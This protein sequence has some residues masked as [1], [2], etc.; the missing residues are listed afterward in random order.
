MTVVVDA[1]ANAQT[2]TS[3]VAHYVS[4]YGVVSAGVGTGYVFSNQN[5]G[6]VLTVA[7]S[8]VGN[9]G[10]LTDGGGDQVI[11]TSTGSISAAEGASS[12]AIILGGAGD[13][14]RISGNVSAID[15][16]VGVVA[17]DTEVVVSQSG[18]VQGGASSPTT[19]R[20][21]AAVLAVANTRLV[22]NGDIIADVNA[23][24]SR[25]AVANASHITPRVDASG[26]WLD[27][28]FSLHFTNTGFV[29]GAVL[30]GAGADTYDGRG[31]GVVEGVIDMGVDDDTFF[32]GDFEEVVLGGRGYDTL[33]GA[34]GPDTLTG[35]D[36][37][38]SLIG[39]ADDDSLEGNNNK[40]TLRGGG[41]ADTLIG[42][43]GGD[44]LAG[45]NEPDVI[46]G[47]AGHDKVFAGNGADHVEGGNGRDTL[48]GNDGDDTIDGG[49]GDDLIKG[50]REMDVLLGM[51][52]HDTLYGEAGDDRL[53][54]GDGND[55]LMGWDGDDVLIGNDDADILRG[56]ANN[57]TLEGGKGADTLNG[58]TGADRL[59]GGIGN[60]FLTGGD[61]HDSL[62]G[63][64]DFDR[65][66][67]GDGNDTLLGDDLPDTL[68]GG[69]G[70]DS[71][72]GGRGG[73]RLIGGPGNDTLR[74][75]SGNDTFVFSG[76]FGR[77]E[78]PGFAGSDNERMDLSGVPTIKSFADLS[79]NHLAFVDGNAVISDGRGNTITVLGTDPADWGPGDFIF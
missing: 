4:Q 57:D 68:W 79:A 8:I 26:F 49:D 2:I 65:L 37:E 41:G 14:A 51:K 16:A 46:R 36:G 15:I 1:L 22:N 73:D 47:E 45:G 27:T 21:S 70:H 33:K 58:G 74:G 3:D 30:F 23:L 31:G 48:N 62:D 75:A 32:G 28:A 34:A 7:G 77:D 78:L 9:F 76:D 54:G 43:N 63:G 5:T 40:D 42:G 38:D 39:G 20:G 60:D 64:M 11:V 66:K 72:E 6:A 29:Y 13:V 52:G 12:D 61:G 53:E 19:N 35:E 67:G 50:G 44:F 69:A 59:F 17:D 55:S 10:V 18:V 25:V 71:L 24:G 56:Q